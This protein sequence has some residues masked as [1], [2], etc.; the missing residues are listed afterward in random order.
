V[1]VAEGLAAY[2]PNPRHRRAQLLAPTPRGRSVLSA[3]N[4]RQE[5]WANAH[6]ARIGAETL[7]RARAL[8]A[9]IRPEIAM[10]EPPPGDGSGS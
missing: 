2:S 8:V 1:L 7:E 10:P 9:G 5:A 6:G 3:I 4:T